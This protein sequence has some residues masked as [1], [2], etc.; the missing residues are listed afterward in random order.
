MLEPQW[1]CWVYRRLYSMV[2][3]PRTYPLDFWN[4]FP[5]AVFLSWKSLFVTRS[6]RGVLWII[7]CP[8]NSIAPR[9]YNHPLFW[10]KDG[11]TKQ[12]GLLSLP[13]QTYDIIV[14]ISRLLF[15]RQ[16]RNRK[17][18]L[19]IILRRYLRAARRKEQ[20]PRGVRLMM[21]KLYHQHRSLTKQRGYAQ[22]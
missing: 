18:R 15:P 11:S 9:A 12:E 5:L 3:A 1:A 14:R 22:T 20:I 10:H 7:W 4:K 16:L 13:Q 19:L 8:F 2:C 6:R 21:E 17:T